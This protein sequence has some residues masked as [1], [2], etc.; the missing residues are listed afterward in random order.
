MWKRCSAARRRRW[1]RSSHGSELEDEYSRL[2]GDVNTPAN[3]LGVRVVHSTQP[4]SDSVGSA[5][6]L[7]SSHGSE[8]EDEYSRL[9][10]D[11]VAN[12]NAKFET[13]LAGVFDA[14]LS[15][16]SKHLGSGSLSPADA[17]RILNLA[18]AGCKR[19]A[20]DAKEFEQRIRSPV[21]ISYYRLSGN[22]E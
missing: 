14:L 6:N 8:L 16:D 21:S 17:A 9:C 3:S 15:S 13:R 4:V 7:D 19:G 11:V 12:A 1:R 2:C 22:L 5:V 10:G 18:A 20:K